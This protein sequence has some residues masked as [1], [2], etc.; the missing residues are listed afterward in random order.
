MTQHF[1][2]SDGASIAYTTR[3]EG[4][5]VICLSGL[6]RNGS[7]FEYVLPHLTGVTAITMDY[8]GRG[9][10]DWSG[11]ETYTIPREMQDVLE[12]MAHLGI[13]K[14]AII[15]TSRGGLIAMTMALV[16]KDRLSGVLLNDIGPELMTEGLGD[17]GNYVGRNPP[18]KTY[19]EAEAVLATRLPGFSNVP[20]GRWAAEARRHYIETPEG[21]KINYDPRL[22]EPVMATFDAEAPDL[23]PVFDAFAG[24]PLAALRGANSNLLSAE[25]FAEM[26][27]RRPDMIAATVPDR[28]HVP[29]L[30]EPESLAVIGEFLGRLR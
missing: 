26:Q 24:L 1:T 11:P 9:Q 3:G 20:E 4:P 29:F 30:D 21:L 10:S 6:T 18:Q 8:R 7:D 17:I 12:L 25:T 15:G 23:W 16:A 27:R 2:A 19:A 28:G 13:G 14:T 22:R 5:A